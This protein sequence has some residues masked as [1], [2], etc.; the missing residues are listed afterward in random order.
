[1]AGRRFAPVFA[2]NFL[3]NLDAI[4]SFLKPEGVAAFQ[5][6]LDRL[7]DD[8][9]PMLTRFPD[10]GRNFLQHPIRSREA[11]TLVRKLKSLLSRT[12]DLREF[13]VD[14]YLLLYLL[15]GRELIFLAIKH[16]RQ[17]SFDLRRFWAQVG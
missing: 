8:V 3:R 7:L 10:A 12:D 13:V 9:V 16:H 6:L 17:L 4:E 2:E 11:R 1:M 14:D 5:R 15:R